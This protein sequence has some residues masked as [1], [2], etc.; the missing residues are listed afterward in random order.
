[1]LV[2]FVAHKSND[3]IKYKNEMLGNLVPNILYESEITEFRKYHLESNIVVVA[4]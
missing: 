3:I 2:V 4:P 1:L